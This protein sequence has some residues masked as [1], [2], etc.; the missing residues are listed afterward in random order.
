MRVTH[1]SRVNQPAHSILVDCLRDKNQRSRRIR[2]ELLTCVSTEG[3]D[4]HRLTFMQISIVSR[5]SQIADRIPLINPCS[6]FD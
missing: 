2:A 6:P 5:E 4:P 3:I 1:R